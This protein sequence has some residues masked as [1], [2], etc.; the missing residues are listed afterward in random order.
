[1]DEILDRKGI[2]RDDLAKATNYSYKTVSAYATTD[3][4][5]S[6]DFLKK[7]SQVLKVSIEEIQ[8]APLGEEAAVHE[9]AIPYSTGAVRVELLTDQHLRDID[10]HLS[11]EQWRFLGAHRS[12]IEES[13]KAI[14]IERHKRAEAA[15]EKARINSGGYTPEQT[16][17]LKKQYGGL[18]GHVESESPGAK[19]H[20]GE[21]PASGTHK[22]SPGQAG[23]DAPPST[24]AAKR[25][26]K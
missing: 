9:E 1:M 8:S 16:D 25:S 17:A 19:S 5:L 14:G 20:T 12:K 11:K 4:A 10:E 26:Q 24:R 6:P 23:P 15:A 18:A 2:S 13:L 21:D 22:V 3:K 7:A